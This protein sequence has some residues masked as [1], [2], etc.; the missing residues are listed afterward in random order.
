MRGRHRCLV[1]QEHDRQFDLFGPPGLARHAQREPTW[2]LL[3]D[4][5]RRVVTSLMVRLILE[6]GCADRRLDRRA[7]DDV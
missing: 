6:H 2:R 7:S 1:A 5:T 4:E 3:P